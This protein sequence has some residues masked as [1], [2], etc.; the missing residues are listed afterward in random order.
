M[1]SEYTVLVHRPFST[2]VKQI[3]KDLILFLLSE[4]LILLH[5]SH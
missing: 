5:Y 4:K 3:A 2:T 1:L